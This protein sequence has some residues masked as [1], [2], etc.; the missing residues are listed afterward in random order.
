MTQIY[1]IKAEIERLL[2][3][4]EPHCGEAAA[5]GARQALYWVKD[6]ME[7]LDK[8]CPLI[9]KHKPCEN[10]MPIAA[11][12][13]KGWVARDES[14]RLGLYDQKPTRSKDL[15]HSWVIGDDWIGRFS[16]DRTAKTTFSDVT[17]ET[18]PI[19]VELTINRV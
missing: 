19:E 13:I 1:Q 15:S 7:S 16:L 2:K 4:T 11:P 8:E 10:Y 18:E 6:F 14:D 3:L 5:D 12:K 9:P 17:W